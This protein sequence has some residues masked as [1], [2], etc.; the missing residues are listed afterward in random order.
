MEVFNVQSSTPTNQGKTLKENPNNMS[1]SELKSEFDKIGTNDKMMLD[2]FQKNNFEK[3]Y[4]DFK[5]A[6]RNSKTGRDLLISGTVIMGVGGIVM[7]FIAPALCN[8]PLFIV[9]TTFFGVG[10]I[11]TITSIP[12]YAVAG[13]RKKGN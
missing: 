6:C 8:Y 10:H 13:A 3:P 11:L 4:N 2:F 7:I 12:I 9:G 5:S 1:S